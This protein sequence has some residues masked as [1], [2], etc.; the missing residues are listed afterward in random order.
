MVFIHDV[1][2]SAKALDTNMP[3]KA[4]MLKAAWFG[5]DMTVQLFCMGAHCV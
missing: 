3:G 4:S 5:G 2:P 1:R